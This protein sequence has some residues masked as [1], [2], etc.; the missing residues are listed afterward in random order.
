MLKITIFNIGVFHFGRGPGSLASPH[1]KYAP[2][3]NIRP[4]I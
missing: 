3:L 2:E 4:L 1:H